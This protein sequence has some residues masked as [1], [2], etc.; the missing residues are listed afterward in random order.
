[1]KTFV[2]VL[3]LFLMAMSIY[4]SPVPEPRGYDR[5]GSSESHESSEEYYPRRYG[6]NFNM[7]I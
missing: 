7:S 6:G 4:S 2:I 3:A 1:M 5:Y